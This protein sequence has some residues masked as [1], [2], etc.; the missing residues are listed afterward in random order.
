MHHEFVLA[1]TD[2]YHDVDNRVGVYDIGLQDQLPYKLNPEFCKDCYKGLDCPNIRPE[3]VLR[4][5]ST[6]Q[7]S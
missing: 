3:G 4:Q 7:V 5:K 6:T 2:I 1:F